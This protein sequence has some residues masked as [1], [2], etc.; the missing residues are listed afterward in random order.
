MKG[1]YYHDSKTYD[2]SKILAGIMKMKSFHLKKNK[3]TAFTL[4][5]MV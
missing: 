4:I 3:C 1:F 2:D 5:S